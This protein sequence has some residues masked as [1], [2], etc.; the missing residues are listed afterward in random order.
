MKL[1]VIYLI[2]SRRKTIEWIKK[3]QS[4]FKNQ[5]KT[6]FHL[7]TISIA[8]LW[9]LASG[10]CLRYSQIIVLAHRNFRDKM[11][12]LM[13]ILLP[14]TLIGKIKMSYCLSL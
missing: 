9:M 6:S 13:V 2:I 8:P 7:E 1:L 12:I 5:L 4:K 14:F 11:N 10:I 3:N